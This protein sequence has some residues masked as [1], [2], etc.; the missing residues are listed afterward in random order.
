V[1][2]TAEEY[3]EQRRVVEELRAKCDAVK[4]EITPL[5]VQEA[6]LRK[7]EYE[8]WQQIRAIKR[9]HMEKSQKDKMTYLRWELARRSRLANLERDGKRKK[10]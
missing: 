4:E 9:W 2:Q 7:K 8:L 3:E 1:A 10:Q 5:Q 6:D